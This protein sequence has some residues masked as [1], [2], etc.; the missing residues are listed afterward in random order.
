MPGESDLPTVFAQRTVRNER[1]GSLLSSVLMR[2]VRPQYTYA[3][4]RH[5]LSLWTTR[6]CHSVGSKEDEENSSR[7]APT[8]LFLE[9][10]FAPESL[11]IISQVLKKAISESGFLVAEAPGK[12]DR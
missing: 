8:V 6:T 7:Q 9:N 10:P 4:R 5:P 1:I 2:S 3:I 11:K 12:A